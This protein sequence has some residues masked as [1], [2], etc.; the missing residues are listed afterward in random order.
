M[1]ARRKRKKRR[2]K[3]EEE[4]RAQTWG[5]REQEQEG[6]TKFIVRQTTRTSRRRK[7]PGA[8]EFVTASSQLVFYSRARVLLFFPSSVCGRWFR[9]VLSDPPALWC[10][11]SGTLLLLL[12]LRLFP[13]LPVNYSRS[14]KI[15][16]IQR[17]HPR[18][19]SCD[20]FREFGAS[21]V[22]IGRIPFADSRGWKIFSFVFE[23][24]TPAQ[25]RSRAI[26]NLHSPRVRD[27]VDPRGKG[28]GTKAQ[29]SREPW[30]S[31]KAESSVKTDVYQRHVSARRFSIERTASSVPGKIR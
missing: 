12:L 6:G 27:G 5:G 16:D 24:R 18:R 19:R 17:T 1:P 25:V 22:Q 8:E 20:T 4:E 15:L 21:S 29:I 3:G 23:S 9:A 13:L 14:V 26:V 2:K 30:K 11:L 10:T 28:Y 7:Y 31:N